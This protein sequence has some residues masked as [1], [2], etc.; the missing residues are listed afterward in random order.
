VTQPDGFAVQD[1]R[2]RR[3]ERTSGRAATR[4]LGGDAAA[5]AGIGADCQDGVGSPS[6]AMAL[7]VGATPPRET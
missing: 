6:T 5:I 7:I 1:R 4:R 2:T 3:T